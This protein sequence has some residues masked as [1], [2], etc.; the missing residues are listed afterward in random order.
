MLFPMVY[1]PLLS[2]NAD[3]GKNPDFDENHENHER[4]MFP[5][6]IRGNSGDVYES[7]GMS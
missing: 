4:F 6:S 5:K 2:D 1:T 7:F 3:T